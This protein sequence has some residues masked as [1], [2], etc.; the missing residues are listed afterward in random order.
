VESIDIVAKEQAVHK[1]ALVHAEH[2][3]GQAR[4]K[5]DK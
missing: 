3:A 4:I 1:V 2:P 5:N